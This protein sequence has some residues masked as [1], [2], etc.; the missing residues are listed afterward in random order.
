MF[1]LIFALVYLFMAAIFFVLAWA[2]GVV[3][4]DEKSKRF[5]I[6]LKETQADQRVWELAHRRNQFPL[7]LIGGLFVLMA[8]LVVAIPVLTSIG[9][10]ALH[11]PIVVLL[12]LL[13]VLWSWIIVKRT[14]AEVRNKDLTGR[15][16]DPE[17]E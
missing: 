3:A 7:M 14:A 15:K 13:F 11:G 6:R 9:Y 4:K 5:G 12:V 16:L 1:R 8:I 2:M 10:I 17:S